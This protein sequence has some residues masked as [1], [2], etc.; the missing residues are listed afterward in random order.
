MP[1]IYK[2]SKREKKTKQREMRSRIRRWKF[3]TEKKKNANKTNKMYYDICNIIY[4]RNE[5]ENEN[6]KSK[7]TVLNENILFRI[8]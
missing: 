2:E 3:R 8:V 1:G 5:N 4:K 7:R 6:E